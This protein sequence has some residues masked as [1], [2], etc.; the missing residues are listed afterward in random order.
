MQASNSCSVEA[1]GSLH[2]ARCQ[3]RVSKSKQQTP[4]SQYRTVVIVDQQVIHKY[5]DKWHLKKII[6]LL[7][8]CKAFHF[9]LEMGSRCRLL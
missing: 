2:W 3:L 1:P 8:A 6:S 5:F 4:C 9:Y 7:M